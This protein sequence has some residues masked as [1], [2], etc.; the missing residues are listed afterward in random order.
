MIV[1]VVVVV[2]VIKQVQRSGDQGQQD[3]E[4]EE[5]NCTNYNWSNR[6]N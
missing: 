3:V 2:V 5:K 1:V 4:S 6:N